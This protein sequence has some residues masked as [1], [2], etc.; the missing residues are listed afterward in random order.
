MRS[1]GLSWCVLHMPWGGPRN[2]AAAPQ[3]NGGHNM[4][5]L[6]YLL[7]KCGLYELFWGC[8]FGH[9]CCGARGKQTQPAQVL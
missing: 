9:V 2:L 4:A 3:T 5:L 8:G 7:I 6:G 1:V